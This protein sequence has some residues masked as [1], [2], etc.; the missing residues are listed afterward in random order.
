[1]PPARNAAAAT[2]AAPTM[3]RHPRP[4]RPRLPFALAAAGFPRWLRLTQA[5]AFVVITDAA[6]S[7]S[8]PLVPRGGV[9]RSVCATAPPFG[10]VGGCWRRG[11]SSGV[12]LRHAPSERTTCAV[13]PLQNDQRNACG[14]VACLP[15]A[16]CGGGAVVRACAPRVS[17]SGTG[18]AGG[19]DV[20][21]SRDVEAC[22]SVFVHTT[23]A[24]SAAPSVSQVACATW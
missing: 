2:A 11:K 14:L 5:A 9:A 20:V 8:R 16:A 3:P 6:P 23:C 24:L 7:A 19:P 22:S 10:W 12:D 15:L 1:M 17:L 18:T 21:V 13:A 4:A